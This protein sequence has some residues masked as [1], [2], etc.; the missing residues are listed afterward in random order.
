MMNFKNKKEDKLR[1][2]RRVKDEKEVDDM[3]KSQTI[4]RKSFDVSP[5]AF[6]RLHL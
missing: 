3:R 6:D 4:L 2:A 1:I 5:D